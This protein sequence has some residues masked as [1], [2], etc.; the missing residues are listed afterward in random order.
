[1]SARTRRREGTYQLRR[2]ADGVVFVEGP[3]SNWTI[4]VGDDSVALIDAGYPRDAPLVLRSIH[5]VAP[6]KPVSDILVTHGHS[7]HIGGIPAL[8][9]AFGASVHAAREEIPNVQ[10]DVLHQVTIRDLGWRLL[11]PRYARWAVH[12]LRA[13]GLDDLSITVDEVIPDDR[14]IIV[15]GHRVIAHLTAGHTPGHVVF[16][17]PEIGALVSGDA[18]ITGHPTVRRR[19]PQMLAP[20]WHSDARR[21]AASASLRGI[22]YHLILP[23]H[24]PAWRVSPPSAQSEP[25]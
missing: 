22:D 14:P 9:A 11:L 7:D 10:R 20:L 15:G 13:G 6:D 2:I 12:A 3:A 4:L 1:V 17:L 23:G 18:V 21:A 24:G 25:L 8:V 19:G 5:E 16:E